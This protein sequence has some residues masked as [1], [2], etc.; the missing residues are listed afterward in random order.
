MSQEP[1]TCTI[2]LYTRRLLAETALDFAEDYDPVMT[3]E[4]LAGEPIHLFPQ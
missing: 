1:C 3:L 2:I 4:D